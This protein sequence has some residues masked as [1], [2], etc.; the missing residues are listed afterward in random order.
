MVKSLIRFF[1][2]AVLFGLLAGCAVPYPIQQ[3][4]IQ[5]G[6]YG[7]HGGISVGGAGQTGGMVQ[8]LPQQ[9]II[10]QQRQSLPPCQGRW[11]Q[12]NQNQF[13]CQQVQ[14]YY[15]VQQVPQGQQYREMVC[16]PQA[17]RQIS[18]PVLPVPGRINCWMAQ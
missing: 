2:V 12:V 9:V 11:V 15:P 8:Q 5:A 6:Y 7:R 16:G 3:G 10:P 1:P 4:N 14:P 13:V 18:G 17:Y